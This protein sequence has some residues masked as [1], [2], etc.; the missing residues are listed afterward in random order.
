MGK[1]KKQ[2]ENKNAN[3]SSNTHETK[4]LARQPRGQQRKL[5]KHVKTYQYTSDTSMQ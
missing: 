1:G 5:A 4:T 2:T 3:T